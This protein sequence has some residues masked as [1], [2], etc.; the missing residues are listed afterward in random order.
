[1]KWL[2][3]VA[4][5]CAVGVPAFGAEV[6]YFYG[7]RA[8]FSDNIRRV[9]VNREEE[10]LNAVIGGVVYQ[11]R[12]PE[13]DLRLAPTLEYLDYRDDTFDDEARLELDSVAIWTISPQRFTWTFEDTARQVR[14]DPTQP[15]TPANTVLANLF[16]TGPD[17]YARFTAVNTLQLGARYLN[18][19][20]QDTQLDSEREQAYLRWLYQYSPIT[21]FSL[22]AETQHAKFDNELANPNFRRDDV[23]VRMDTRQ[24]RSTVVIDLGR[25]NVKRDGFDEAEGSLARL[26]WTRRSTAESTFGV[27]AESAFSDTGADL[28]ATAAAATAGTA[29]TVSQNLVSQD[30]FRAKRG[31]VFYERAG[32]QFASALRLFARELEFQATPLD[33][34]DEHGGNLTVNYLYS[35]ATSFGIYGERERIKYRNQVL[36]DTDTTVGVQFLR[37]LTPNVTVTLELQREERDSTDPAREFVDDR[38]LF[39]VV[40]SSGI[41]PRGQ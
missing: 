27:L 3:A 39:S 14:V 25:T 37:R 41:L 15:E 29:Q 11:D 13:L 30:I 12:T 35:A 7:Y 26:A 22:N 34:R 1:M 40:Y 18:V 32:T 38:V 4:A 28:A 8:E 19:Y 17:V 36:I 31:E 16:N 20:L 24:A 23:F 33:D 9:P 5:T 6:S 21:V 2:V 10:M